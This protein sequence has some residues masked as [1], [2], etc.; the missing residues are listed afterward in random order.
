MGQAFLLLSKLRKQF[1]STV[2]RKNMF[3]LCFPS[4][5]GH[6]H[7]LHLLTYLSFLK[8]KETQHEK[9]QGTLSPT[10]LLL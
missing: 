1:S 5:S 7:T 4:C 8:I 9:S 2:L 6:A 10:L 3:E